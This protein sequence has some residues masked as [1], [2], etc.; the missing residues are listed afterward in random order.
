MTWQRNEGRE[1]DEVLQNKFTAYLLSAVQRR[2]ALYIDTLVKAQQISRLIEE[3]AMDSTFELEQEALQG[4]PLYMR[5]QNEKLF[6]SLSH[7]TERERYVF[8]NR[9]LDER[10]LDELAAELGLS[11]KGVAAVYYRALQKIK[12]EMKGDSL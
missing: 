2:K 5:I 3:T 9:A 4:I 12:K 6:W 8:F 7:L 11:Y 1:Q 10:S